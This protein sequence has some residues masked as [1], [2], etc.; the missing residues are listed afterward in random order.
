MNVR[1]TEEMADVEWAIGSAVRRLLARNA[2]I[3]PTNILA[4]LTVLTTSHNPGEIE[5]ITKAIAWIR[6]RIN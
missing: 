1:D 3:I 4:E 6:A 2:E 5:K